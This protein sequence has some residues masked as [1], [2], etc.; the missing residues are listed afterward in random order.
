[1]FTKMEG[2]QEYLW[3]Q[4]IYQYYSKEDVAVLNRFNHDIRG[5]KEVTM[6]SLWQLKPKSTLPDVYEEDELTE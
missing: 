1:M 6:H 5:S 4:G 3:D 2:M